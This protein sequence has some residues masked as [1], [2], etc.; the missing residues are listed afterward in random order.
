MFFFGNL[1]T[2]HLSGNFSPYV[3][4]PGYAGSNDICLMS[5]WVTCQKGEYIRANT[6]RAKQ[7]G[8]KQKGRK[9][10]GRK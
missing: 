2:G 4:S 10:K 3:P 1:A 9:Q 8:R 7:K 5:V 6:K